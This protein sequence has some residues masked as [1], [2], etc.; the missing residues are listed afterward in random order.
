MAP[1]WVYLF[2]FFLYFI[3]CYPI[4]LLSKKMEKNGL[5]K[6]KGNG[7]VSKMADS[8]VLLELSDI[9]RI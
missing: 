2:I 4:T 5:F 6:N 3:I 8:E 9:K 1:F 7:G